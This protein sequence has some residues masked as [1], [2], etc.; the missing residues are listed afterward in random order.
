MLVTL[1]G[2]CVVASIPVNV[3][4]CF[5]IWG[6]PAEYPIH[7]PSSFFRQCDGV[8]AYKTVAKSGVSEPHAEYES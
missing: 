3:Q 2:S 4:I 5:G 6:L 8:K 7:W 1:G